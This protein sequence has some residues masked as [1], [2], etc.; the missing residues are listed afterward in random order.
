MES[1]KFSSELQLEMKYLR[2][3]GT[4]DIQVKLLLIFDGLA[5]A[6][7]GKKVTLT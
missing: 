4:T 6:G 5:T 3:L 7:Q 1:S 2:D